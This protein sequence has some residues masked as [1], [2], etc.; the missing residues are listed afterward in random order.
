MGVVPPAQA[1]YHPDMT[2]FPLS[3]TRAQSIGR[4][5]GAGSSAG[6]NPPCR[7]RLHRRKAGAGAEAGAQAR[8]RKRNTGPDPSALRGPQQA[9][10]LSLAQPET[11]ARSPVPARPRR[12]AA[13]WLA[14]QNRVGIGHPCSDPAPTAAV[15]FELAEGGGATGHAPSKPRLRAASLQLGS[16]TQSFRPAQSRSPVLL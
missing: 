10:A 14:P 11:P 4:V 9:P 2:Q 15:R 5:S 8:K 7:S 13:R 1:Y 16:P 3:P 12:G 6:A